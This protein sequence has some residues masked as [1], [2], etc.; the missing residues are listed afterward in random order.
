M[1]L[2]TMTIPIVASLILFTLIHDLESGNKPSRDDKISRVDTVE[3]RS[4]REALGYTQPQLAQLL[5]VKQNTLS[6]WES[7]TRSLPEGIPVELAAI[8][9]DTREAIDLLAEA[10]PGWCDAPVLDEMTSRYG[11]RWRRVAT[12]RAAERAGYRGSL[13]VAL[14]PP[15]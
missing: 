13:T 14:T 12:V 11:A 1:N 2:A 7:G 15:S 5:Q 6:Q 4:R 3:L 9:V 8:E 10:L